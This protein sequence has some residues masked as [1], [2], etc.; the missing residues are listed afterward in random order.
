MLYIVTACLKAGVP[1]EETKRFLI[2][3][4]VTTEEDSDEG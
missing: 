2:S 1:H 4:S 3:S